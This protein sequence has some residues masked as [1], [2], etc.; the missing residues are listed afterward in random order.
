MSEPPN[1]TFLDSP[2]ASSA[3]FGIASQRGNR[4][5]VVRIGGTAFGDGQFVVVAGPCAVESERQIL[6]AA[7]LVASAGGH[8][9]RGGAFKARTSPYAF[10]GLGL[11]GVLLMRAAADA[12]GLPM[13]TEVL[14]QHDVEI[15]EPHVDAF[16]VGS[17]NMDNTALLKDLGQTRKPVMLKRGFASTIREWLLAA[18]Y[19][20]LGGNDQV[21]LCERGIRTFSDETRFTLDLAGAVLAHQ[22]TALP[23]IID[24]SHATG[25][26]ALIPALAAATIAAGLDGLM[27]EVHPNPDAALSDA[28]QA[29]SPEQFHAMMERL[30]AF[31][32]AAGFRM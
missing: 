31:A 17:R 2:A 22:Q 27:V 11:E 10:Q 25:N 29:L 19:I 30:R 20:L 18:E 4:R 32:P 16:Q 23:I 14:S 24:P 1:I 6:E 21:V 26:P 5:H 15:M 9:L 12:T 28:D 7:R 3:A 8:I 13:V